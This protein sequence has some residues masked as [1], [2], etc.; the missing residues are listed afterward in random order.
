MDRRTFIGVVA[1][2]G[3][4]GLCRYAV[5][6]PRLVIVVNPKNPIR[7]LG[8]GEIEA[9]FTTRRLDWPGGGG[10]IIAFN[11]PPR[12][13]AREEFDRRALHMEPNEV[14]RFWIDRRVRGGHP[15]P[16]Q[17]PD[18]RTMV[19]VVASLENAVGYV[20]NGEADGSVRVIAEV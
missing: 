4:I 10:R 12:H 8:A 19:R 7:S 16:R 15:P 18:A 20:A 11:F 3:V 13:P 5:A 14:A 17:I 6:A 1:A 9:I 2:A